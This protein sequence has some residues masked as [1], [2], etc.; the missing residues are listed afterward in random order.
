MKL[1]EQIN[2][3]YENLSINIYNKNKHEILHTCVIGSFIINT[4]VTLPNIPKYSR[5]FSADVCQESPP[6]NN[7]PAG[8]ESELLFNWFGVDL[9]D[10]LPP[11]EFRPFCVLLP[12]LLL[13]LVLLLLILLL[14][15]SVVF[16][17]LTGIKAL[18][19][20]CNSCSV[21]VFASMTLEL[22]KK[23]KEKK[24]TNEIKNRLIYF[25]K[26]KKYI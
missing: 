25:T 11:L 12:L 5:N 4:S 16:T 10:E 22:F 8:E 19:I 23:K 24:I 15:F 2:E 7:F 9:P 21:T 6:T 17:A 14:Q 18:F 1:N 13:V 3:L 26:Y 20:L